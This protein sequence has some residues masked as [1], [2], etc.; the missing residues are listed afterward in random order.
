PADYAEPANHAVPE[1]RSGSE[2][3]SALGSGPAGDTT[4][5]SSDGPKDR[6]A[7]GLTA[8]DL[9]IGW[10]GGPIVAGPFD[11]DIPRGTAMAVVGP[12]GIGKT[13]LLYTLAGLLHPK[14]GT[15]KLD[16]REASSLP[17]DEVSRTLVLTAEDA[18]VFATTVLENIRVARASVTEHEATELLRRAGL[19][20]WLAELPEGVHTMLG[21]DAT[22]ISGGE[23]RR[24]LFARALASSAQ[25]LLLDEPAEHLDGETA[26]ALLTDLIA[27]AKDARQR[28]R[29]I[30][31]VTH[32]LSPL[33]GADRVILLSNDGGTTRVAAAGTHAELVSL[34]PDYRWSLQQE[35]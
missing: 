15:V 33:A 17:R 21:Q 7:G 34:M 6:P 1:P 2:H 32:R 22:T 27:A 4:A 24:L 30:V 11:L 12:S 8:R 23:R 20:D 3:P 19:G 31:I 13:T 29:T 9:H 25:F 18:H 16:G 26:D 14:S 35:K 5:G 10:P 28:D